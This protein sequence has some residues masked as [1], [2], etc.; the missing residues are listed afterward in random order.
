LCIPTHTLGT[1]G[2]FELEVEFLQNREISKLSNMETRKKEK[3]MWTRKINVFIFEVNK[4]K[5]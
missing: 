4:Q 2:N 5:N 1:I 3:K